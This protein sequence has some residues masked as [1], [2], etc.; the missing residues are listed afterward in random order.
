MQSMRRTIFA[1]VLLLSAVL[2]SAPA[3]AQAKSKGVALTKKNF[4]DEEVLRE[5][6]KY[7]K[8]KNRYLSKKELAAVTEIYWDWSFD[9]FSQL[10]F[11]TNLRSLTLDSFG[12]GL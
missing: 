5:V 2:L 7:D 1:G 3:A 8:D 9:D 6:K 4:P 11:F 10:R 12:T